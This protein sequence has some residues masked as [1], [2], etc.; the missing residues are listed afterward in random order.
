MQAELS[1]L[2]CLKHNIVSYPTTLMSSQRIPY[3]TV[4]D[5]FRPFS[6]IPSHL[7]FSTSNWR[8]DFCITVDYF[9]HGRELAAFC[10][11]KLPRYPSHPRSQLNAAILKTFDRW[12]D[13]RRVSDPSFLAPY[14]LLLEN[15]EIMTIIIST[16]VGLDGNKCAPNKNTPE[17][18][19]KP[20]SVLNPRMMTLRLRMYR[21]VTM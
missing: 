5:D 15:P 1:Y 13:E 3:C 9:V 10:L 6:A 12:T 19:E 16:L 7:P 14:A 21:I 18:L 8:N 17:T 20:N 2:L 4:S 11:P